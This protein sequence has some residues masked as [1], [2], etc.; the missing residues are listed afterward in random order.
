MVNIGSIISSIEYSR[1]NEG[2]A[3]RIKIRAGT[4]VQIISIAVP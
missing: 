1:V 2:I 4:I 3:T